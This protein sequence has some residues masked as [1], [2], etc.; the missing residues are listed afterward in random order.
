MN[1][2]QMWKNFY[3]K[4]Q[5]L[6][7]NPPTEHESRLQDEDGGFFEKFGSLLR[8]KSHIEEN[9]LKTNLAP[10]AV[11]SENETEAH[12]EWQVIKEEES[13]T[14][15]REELDCAAVQSLELK[16]DLSIEEVKERKE[17]FFEKSV[18]MNKLH[19]KEDFLK[20][21]STPFAEESESE[22]NDEWEIVNAEGPTRNEEQSLRMIAEVI[23]IRKQEFTMKSLDIGVSFRQ[24][25]F[26]AYL[27]H[28]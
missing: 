9:S 1:E 14:S 22:S 6:K 15:S 4:L 17:E 26:T 21:D 5:E 28:K 3:E 10:F 27:S 2:E 19:C 25:F 12:E 23:K 20:I 13:P 7:T 8:Q 11:E 16:R 24:Y 18:G